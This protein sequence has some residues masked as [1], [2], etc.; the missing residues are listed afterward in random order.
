[1]CLKCGKGYKLENGNCVAMKKTIIPPEA[2][3]YRYAIY[4]GLLVSAAIIL[5]NNV[6]LA[7]LVGLAAAMYISI[8]EYIM[9][10]HLHDLAHVNSGLS[11]SSSRLI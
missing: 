2:N 11:T 10:T 7:S 6:Y 3:Y 8:S 1:M 4:A 5:H 9:S